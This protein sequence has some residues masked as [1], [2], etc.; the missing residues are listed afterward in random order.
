[1]NPDWE[2]SPITTPELA[3]AFRKTLE[4]RQPWENHYTS[5]WIGSMSAG[6]Y[7]R[8]FDGKMVEMILDRHITRSVKPSLVSVFGGAGKGSWQIDGN[9]G[10]S[11]A[12]GETLLQSRPVNGAEGIFEIHLLPALFPSWTSGE[13]SGLCAR[14]GYVVDITWKDSAL[15]RATILAKL[16]GTCRLR[17]KTPVRIHSNGKEISVKILG[18]GLVEFSANSGEKY[19]ITLK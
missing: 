2:I 16:D 12:I 4:I 7:A 11:S 17:T 18:D 6:N 9:L 13:V 19:E 8:L 14:G 5:S 1:L 15:Q 10:M 3:A